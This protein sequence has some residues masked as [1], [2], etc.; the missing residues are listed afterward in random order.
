MV[1]NLISATKGYEDFYK[2]ELRKDGDFLSVIL[3]PITYGFFVNDVMRR[4]NFRYPYY[5]QTINQKICVT[6]TYFDVT[7]MELEN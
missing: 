1:N 6:S 7:K 5:V 2:V 3:T 4:I